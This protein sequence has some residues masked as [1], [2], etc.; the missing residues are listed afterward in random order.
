VIV[1]APAG[2]MH[3]CR[4]D[5]ANLLRW[6]G[7]GVVELGADTP[8]EALAERPSPSRT[9]WP[10]LSA[11]PRRIPPSGP[12]GDCRSAGGDAQGAGSPRW[13][14]ITTA[15]QAKRLGADMFTAAVPTRLVHALEAI[16]G[17][18]Q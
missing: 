12:T 8:S 3:S 17:T 15:T 11:A 4:S 2:E 13:R 9:L 6:H 18:K 16:V 7:F 5:G 1:T 10:W 14:R